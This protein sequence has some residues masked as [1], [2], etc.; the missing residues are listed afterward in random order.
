MSAQ[1][2]VCSE[3]TRAFKHVEKEVAFSPAW[4][5]GH[6]GYWNGA[7]MGLMAPSLAVGEVVK[8]MDDF[9][10]RAIFI[11]SKKGNIV[12]FDRYR[13]TDGVF[14]GQ[15]NYQMPR[16]HKLIWFFGSAGACDE[17]RLFQIV[18]PMNPNENVGAAL[19]GN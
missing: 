2:T 18:N 12:L 4:I 7:V 19:A 17:T 15:I 8:T 13:P 5:R 6:N 1:N 10:R 3:F 16:D 14:D 9:G 11:G